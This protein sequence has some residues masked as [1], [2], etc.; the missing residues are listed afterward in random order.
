MDTVFFIASKVIWALISPDSLIAILA[1]GAWISLMLGWQKLSRRLLSL[2]ALLVV[3]IAFLPLG[4]W[5]IS[6]LENRFAAN[7]ALPQEVHGI[8][9]LSGAIKPYES[10][11][12][13]QVELDNGAE[14]LT[15]FVYLANLYPNAQL[16]FTGGNGELAEQEYKAADFAGY[17]FDQLG[18]TQRAIIFE[19]ESRNTFENAVNSKELVAPNPDE[20]WILVTSAY[21]MPRSVGIFCQQDWNV[22]PYAVDHY[23]KRG[24]LYRVD[25][26]FSN[27]LGI[28]RIAVREWVGLI[29]YR[30][31]GRTNQFLPSQSNYCG[32]ETDAATEAF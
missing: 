1:I 9:V 3:L 29:A 8:V 11:H 2:C 20:Q 22:I 16:V 10:D 12:W 28:L 23:S 25:F 7:T 18:L 24:D 19:R 14:R 6:P 17:L 30:I 31:T 13:N 15:S 27:N 21:H 5:I 26:S 32:A 4:E